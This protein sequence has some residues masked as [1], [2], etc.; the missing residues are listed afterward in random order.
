MG[1]L[2]SCVVIHPTV[3]PLGTNSVFAITDNTTGEVL[4]ETIRITTMQ[5][6]WRDTQEQHLLDIFQAKYW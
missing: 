3:V 6:W 1:F 2:G 5:L 4:A